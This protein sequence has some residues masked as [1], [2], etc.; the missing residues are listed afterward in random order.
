M[1][2][3]TIGI[4]TIWKSERITKLVEDLQSEEKVDEILIIDNLHLYDGRFDTLN[5]V[6]VIQ[7]EENLY[8]NPAW[9]RIVK[10]SKNDLVGLLN[11]DINFDTNI[12]KSFNAEVLLNVGIVGMGQ[13]NYEITEFEGTPII[14]DAKY[15][16]DGGWG[17]MLLLHKNHWIPIPESLKIWY[18]D[19]FIKSVNPYPNGT[20]RGLP[21]ETEMS[22]TSNLDEVIGVRDNDTRIWHSGNL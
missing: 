2:K 3:F 13:E 7:A 8:V 15:T 1:E 21:I 9:N 18:G 22:T 5:K 14:T 11:D 4:P 6:R 19:N 17:C 20:L 10:E 16:S 12:F